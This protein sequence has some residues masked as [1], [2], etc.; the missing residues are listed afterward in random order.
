MSSVCSLSL[1][2]IQALDLSAH[3]LSISI[4]V[5]IGRQT[6][7]HFFM[8]KCWIHSGVNNR[9]DCSNNLIMYCRI[10][11]EQNGCPALFFICGGIALIQRNRKT[12]LFLWVLVGRNRSKNL[13]MCCRIFGK[14]NGRPALFF[15]CGD[16]AFLRRNSTSVL[17]LKVLVGRNRSNNLILYCRIYGERNGCPALFFI[18]GG[19]ALLRRNST[20]VL[21]LKFLVGRSIVLILMCS[22]C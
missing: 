16:I 3:C 19:I 1:S 2:G 8:F 5:S 4:S 7:L 21:F 15:V 12:V 11:G 17:F 20:S 10:S 14:R 6:R 9:L 22:P 13:I 18:C